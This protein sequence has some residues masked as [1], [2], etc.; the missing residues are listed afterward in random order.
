MSP[1][2]LT[3]DREQQQGML[4]NDQ[5]FRQLIEQVV[6]QVLQAEVTE[7]LQAERYERTEEC[8]GYRNGTKSRQVTTRVGTLHLLV[9]QV[10]EGGFTTEVLARYERQEQA[11]L[12]TLM[13]MVVNGVSTRKVS[14]ITEELCGKDFS[15]STVSAL[16]HQLDPLVQAWNERRLEAQAFPFVIV[17]HV[18]EEGHVRNV[19]AL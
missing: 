10:R 18:R 3:V 19:S 17:I 1:S 16:C 4:Q 5:S 11:L 2:Q 15:K 7:H 12:L 13:E 6:N 14:R 9:P 8:Q